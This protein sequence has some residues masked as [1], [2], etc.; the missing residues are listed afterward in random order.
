MDHRASYLKQK[1]HIMVIDVELEEWDGSNVT[2]TQ[3]VGYRRKNAAD[4]NDEPAGLTPRQGV[5]YRNL[6][7]LAQVLKSREIPVD[8]VLRGRQ[9]Y[10]DR[11]CIKIAEH[12][13][14][15]EPITDGPSG[16]VENICLA[17]RC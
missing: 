4:F 12:A 11:G 10:L 2:H 14:F 15:I 7:R 9:V 3:T 6:I 13:G 1:G 17:W 16:S 8:F 5:F